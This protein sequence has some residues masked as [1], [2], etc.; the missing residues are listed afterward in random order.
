MEQ[1]SAT[2]PRGN[3]GRPWILPFALPAGFPATDLKRI[4]PA[5]VERY[6]RAPVDP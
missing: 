6:H 3:Q 4:G 2:T 5:L 1:V